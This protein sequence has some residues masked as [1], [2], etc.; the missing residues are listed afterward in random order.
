MKHYS[1]SKRLAIGI[2]AGTF[3]LAAYCANK[4]LGDAVGMVFMSGIPAGVA[5]YV[6]K[7]YTDQKWGEV[8]KNIKEIN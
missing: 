3:V 7:L 4:G 1:R 2:I 6:G 8:E 5:L